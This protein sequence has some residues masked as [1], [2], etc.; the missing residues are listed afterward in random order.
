LVKCR[1]TAKIALEE[2]ERERE[3]GRR[4]E[5]RG[6]VGTGIGGRGVRGPWGYGGV[7]LAAMWRERGDRM[8]LIIA[9][10]FIEMKVCIFF[11]PLP[12]FLAVGLCPASCSPN[13]RSLRLQHVFCHHFAL[14]PRPNCA[15]R[16]G[17]YT[18][19]RYSSTRHFGYNSTP[20]RNRSRTP[21]RHLHLRSRPR[22]CRRTSAGSDLK[23]LE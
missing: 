23:C 10:Q 20:Y 18:S 17:G 5:K 4:G 9:S 14:H 16:W 15:R 13:T 7:A 22:T 8:A 2:G 21:L 1:L 11:S 3:R 12:M 6:R 19:K